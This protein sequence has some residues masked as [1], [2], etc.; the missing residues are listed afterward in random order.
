MLRL[1]TTVL[2]IGILAIA[3]LGLLPAV[4]ADSWKD[5]EALINLIKETG[6]E[7][8]RLDDCDNEYKGLYIFEPE[9]SLDHLILCENNADLSD[10]SEIWEILSHEAT[11]VMQACIGGTLFEG[12]MHPRMIREIQRKTPHYYE[13]LSSSYHG[14]DYILEAEAFWMELQPPSVVM[15]LFLIAC[16]NEE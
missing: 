10:Q 13:I 1:K 9:K 6:T 4:R 8:H 12:D 2:H 3:A 7:L 14:A 16:F 11:H 5:I 15:E